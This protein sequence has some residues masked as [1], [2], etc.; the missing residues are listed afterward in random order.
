MKNDFKEEN[1][2]PY[3]GADDNFKMLVTN[4]LKLPSAL[5]H[6]FSRAHDSRAYDHHTKNPKSLK[7]MQ[8][9]TASSGSRL[10]TNYSF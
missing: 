7:F 9:E 8:Q 10:C 4:M 1:L 5:S 2:R 6:Q 3:D